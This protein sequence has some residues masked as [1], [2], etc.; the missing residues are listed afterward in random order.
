MP[1][2]GPIEGLAVDVIPIEIEQ[3]V[4]PELI[5]QKKSE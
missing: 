5:L 4:R 3:N 2:V 1:I